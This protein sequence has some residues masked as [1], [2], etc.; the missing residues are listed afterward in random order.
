MSRLAE[1]P[2]LTAIPLFAFTGFLLA[3][4]GAATR[5]VRPPG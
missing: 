5:L 1:T 3:E 4:S 2:T